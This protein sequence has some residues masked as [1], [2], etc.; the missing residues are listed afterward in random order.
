MTAPRS[1]SGA[2]LAALLLALP[3]T[4]LAQA[5]PRTT[6]APAPK[7]A[8]APA[9]EPAPPSADAPM[10]V[11]GLM[12]LAVAVGRETVSDSELAGVR[13]QLEL[14]RELVPLGRRGQ[15]SLLAAAA[16]FHGTRSDTIGAGGATLTVDTTQELL[17]LVPAF[18]ASVALKPRLRF[19]AEVGVGGAWATAKTET[20]TSLA[21][22][23][24]T[25]ADTTAFAGV[26]RLSAGATWQLSDRL[27][28]GVQLP[29]LQRRYG[30]ATSQSLS[31]SAMAAYAL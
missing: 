30:E 25:T 27:R 11:S 29:S 20:F 15:L 8:P 21:P 1:L 10:E 4:G 5:K 13:V 3:A 6:A 12:H 2:A 22:G 14:E 28:L 9:E 16:W 18:R 26:L 17:E 24:S 19:F 7:P 31:F 23:T